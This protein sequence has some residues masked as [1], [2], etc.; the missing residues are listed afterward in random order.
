MLD[1]RRPCPIGYQRERLRCSLDL[2]GA[3]AQNAPV[4]RVSITY[5]SLLIHDD[6]SILSHRVDQ[7]TSSIGIEPGRTAFRSPCQ[8][9]LAEQSA[10]TLKRDLL[11]HVVVVDEQHLLRLLLEYLEYDNTERVHAGLHDA[12]AGRPIDE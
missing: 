8:N 11:D 7:L 3:V 9:G 4:I 5:A 2:A 10:G 1:S 12:P 6:D